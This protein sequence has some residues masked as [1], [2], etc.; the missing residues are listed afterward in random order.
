MSCA[1]RS[2]T[3]HLLAKPRNRL[4]PSLLESCRPGTTAVLYFICGTIEGNSQIWVAVLLFQTDIVPQSLRIQHQTWP[5][6]T[7]LALKMIEIGTW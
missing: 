4:R 5:K 1:E 6:I 3:N 7:I 2:N